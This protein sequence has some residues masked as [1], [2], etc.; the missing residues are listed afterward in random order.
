MVTISWKGYKIVL[1]NSA[2]KLHKSCINIVKNT[3]C[4]PLADFVG[5]YFLFDD[6]IE[7]LKTYFNF[8]VFLSFLDYFMTS[9]YSLIFLH[10]SYIRPYYISF[11]TFWKYLMSHFI[12][13]SN[14]DSFYY[15]KLCSFCWVCKKLDLY[16]LGF[17]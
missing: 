8:I 16:Y 11:F 2:L 6:I 13:V 3:H 1:L 9:S 10:S 7:K 15:L 5:T 12:Q 17:F 4:R 14:S